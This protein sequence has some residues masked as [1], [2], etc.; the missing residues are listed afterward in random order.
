LLHGEAVGWGM[1]A[2]LWIA[3]HRGTISA[4]QME[5]LERLIYAYGPLPPLTVRAARVVAA[6][7]GDKKNLGGVRR[8]VLPVGIGDAGVV[9][10]VTPMELEAAV[11][12]TLARARVEEK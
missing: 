3:R 2:A 12:Y 10:D 9:D 1:V 7:T 11:D 4:A 6:S 8:F 5:R